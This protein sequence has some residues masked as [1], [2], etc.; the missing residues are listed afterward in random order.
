[1]ISSY[2]DCLFTLVPAAS[3][4]IVYKSDPCLP[5][6]PGCLCVYINLGL[7]SHFTEDSSQGQSE[8][9]YSGKMISRKDCMEK[10]IRLIAMKCV[11]P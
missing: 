2:L 4:E 9:M 3:L 1:M 10:I 6:A 8:D 7:S 5:S 11:I